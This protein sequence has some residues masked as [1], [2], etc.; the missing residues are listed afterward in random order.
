MSMKTKKSRIISVVLQKGGV[1]KTTTVVSLS[2]ALSILGY[3][4]LAIDIDP[5][6][7]L[8]SQFFSEEEMESKFTIYDLLK[9]EAR[10]DEGEAIVLVKDVILN[11]EKGDV[12][13]DIIPATQAL[14]Q[15]DYELISLP[16]REFLLKKILS[17]IE[18]YDFIFIDCPPSLGVL[19]VN[20][21]S[22]SDDNELII[23]VKPGFYSKLGVKILN[24]VRKNLQRKIGATQKSFHFLITMFDERKIQHN[25]TIKDIEAQFTENMIFDTKIRQTEKI[26]TSPEYGLDIFN[27]APNTNGT[28]D[29][30]NLA[31][32]I[33]KNG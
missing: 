8:T 24:K 14:G 33:V 3:K 22:C 26:S 31:K 18:G 23:T 27:Y 4:V 9:E 12:K 11:Y 30:M 5:Q 13:F 28:I 2:A 7:N 32:E 1:G 29:Y 20:V 6:G 15:A 16:G 19:T 25:Q 21:L 10:D 17:K